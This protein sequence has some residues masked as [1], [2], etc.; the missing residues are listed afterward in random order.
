MRRNDAFV[1]RR[2]LQQNFLV[3]EC[4]P[5][6]TR[7]KIALDELKSHDLLRLQTRNDWYQVRVLGGKSLDVLVQ[8]GPKFEKWTLAKLSETTGVV[9]AR[10]KP[11][12]RLGC[13][14]RF[15]LKD[16]GRVVSEP[17]EHLE[18]CR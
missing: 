18:V 14:V 4:Q 10:D 16:D 7:N 13:S 3:E 2:T 5:P 17:I 9:T 11:A 1:W 12:I 8:G 15:D 6:Q